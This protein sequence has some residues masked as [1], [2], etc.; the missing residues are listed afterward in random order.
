M[1]SWI[2]SK[3]EL[4]VSNSHGR[5]YFA[6]EKIY[7]NEV[8]I[9]QGGRILLENDLDEDREY[10]KYA[11]YCFQVQDD[12][13]ICPFS[14]DE[15]DL[16]GIFLVNHSC[17]PNCGFSGQIS[18]VAMRDIQIDEEIVFD[19]SMTDFIDTNFVWED[20][21]CNCGSK[22]CRGK[23]T[24]HDWKLPDLVKKYNGYFSTHIQ[25]KINKK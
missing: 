22:S 24:G 25:M 13:Y 17:D 14:L 21:I 5:G 4:Q 23:I 18:L 7:K 3:I 15:K 6:K 2:S 10:G 20:M 16:D 9:V 1:F 19:Y 11:Y 8:L 12:K